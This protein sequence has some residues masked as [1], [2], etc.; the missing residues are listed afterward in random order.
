MEPQDKSTG[1]RD[2]HYGLV[3]VLYHALQGAE[4]C[5]TYAL[6]ALETGR[7]DLATFFR[8]SDTHLLTESTEKGQKKG[9][10]LCLFCP[11]RTQEPEPLLY[12]RSPK[13][14]FY[15]TCDAELRTPEYPSL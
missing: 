13:K 4:N 1:T 12:G 10:R 5:D 6:D 8:E 11:R 3:S 2:G 7:D 14:R 15:A 9:C